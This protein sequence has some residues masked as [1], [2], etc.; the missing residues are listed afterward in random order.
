MVFTDLNFPVFGLIF[1]RLRHF[2]TL[3]VILLNDSN[4]NLVSLPSSSH[5]W[6]DPFFPSLLPFVVKEQWTD[7]AILQSLSWLMPV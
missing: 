7:I 5:S 2:P 6:L 4:M 3:A 1:Q